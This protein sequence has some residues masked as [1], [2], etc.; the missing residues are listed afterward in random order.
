MY[1]CA[2]LYM[3][4]CMCVLVCMCVYLCRVE[5]EE[6]IGWSVTE[7]IDGSEPSVGAKNQTQVSCKHSW[8]S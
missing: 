2:L 3:C 6:G 4:V 8:C 1:M 7:V 5:P